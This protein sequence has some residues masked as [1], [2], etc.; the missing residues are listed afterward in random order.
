MVFKKFAEMNAQTQQNFMAAIEEMKKPSVLD[1][2]KLDK[3][4]EMIRRK[5]EGR[6]QA[7][8][9]EEERNAYLLE[10]C[11]HTMPSTIAGLPGRHAWVAA[12]QSDGYVRPFCNVC[13][14][15]K[16]GELKF[17]AT[18]YMLQNGVGLNNMQGINV[19]KLQTWAAQK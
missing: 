14:Y 19:D 2:M 6:V 15:G 3:E 7:A 10:H 18:Q 1:Q 4:E 16:N 5:N 17:K 9:L 13:K 8:K 11:P 12:V